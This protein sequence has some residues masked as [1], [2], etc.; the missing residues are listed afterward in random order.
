MRK[1]TAKWISMSKAPVVHCSEYI[2]SASVKS[3]ASSMNYG[4]IIYAKNIENMF[5]INIGNWK[6]KNMRFYVL[7]RRDVTF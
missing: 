2:T 4:Y 1:W 7:K 6:Y 5:R 3:L